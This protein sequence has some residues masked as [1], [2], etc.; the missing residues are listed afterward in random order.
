KILMGTE[1]ELVLGAKEKHR[2]AIHEGG[3]ALV[4]ALT[5]DADPP[6]R[7]SIIPRGMALGAT[8]QRPENDRFLVDAGELEARIR[9]LLGGYVAES[10]MLDRVS[11]GAED[12]LRRASDIARRMVASYG[13]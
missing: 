5:P 13:M 3:H 12:D 4:A 11:T 2:V 10:I 8:Q 1:R 7:I 6:R 9:V